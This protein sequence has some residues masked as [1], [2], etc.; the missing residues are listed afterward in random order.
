MVAPTGPG[1]SPCHH[2][3]QRN[4]A[5]AVSWTALV[6]MTL[7]F[8]AEGSS[9]EELE[10]NKLDLIAELQSFSVYVSRRVYTFKEEQ[11]FFEKLIR[12]LE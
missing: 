9:L 10:L 4:Q 12:R 1:L 6:N 3:P 7:S 2:S 5:A 11:V 8:T